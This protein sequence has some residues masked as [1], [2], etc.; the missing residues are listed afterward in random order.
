MKTCCNSKCPLCWT[1][2][3]TKDLYMQK[4]ST[5]ALLHKEGTIDKETYKHNKEQISKYDK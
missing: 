5:N 1:Q 3:D 2:K 4:Q